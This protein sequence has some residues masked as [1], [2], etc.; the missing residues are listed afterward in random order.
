MVTDDPGTPG[1]GHWE[2]NVAWSFEHSR[3]ANSSEVPLVDA[4]FGV[5]DRIQLKYKVPWI[6]VHDEPLSRT[7]P[8]RGA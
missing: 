7:H 1:D 2:I 5:G 6:V 4:N 8:R 3:A